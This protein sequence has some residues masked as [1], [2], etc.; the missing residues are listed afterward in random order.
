MDRW[1]FRGFDP[2]SAIERRLTFQAACGSQEL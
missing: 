1:P 2:R